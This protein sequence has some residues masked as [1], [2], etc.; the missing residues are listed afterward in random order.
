MW[1]SQRGQSTYRKAAVDGSPDFMIASP[2]RSPKASSDGLVW[3]SVSARTSR[4]LV[5]GSVV[6]VSFEPM[7]AGCTTVSRW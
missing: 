7:F 6:L 2:G 1:L 4:W 5:L 3:E